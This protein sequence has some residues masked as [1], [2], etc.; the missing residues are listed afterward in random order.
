M[1]PLARMYVWW[2]GM[3][4]EIKKTVRSVPSVRLFKQ[5]L[6]SLLSTLGN[7][8]LHHGWG[9]TWT[10][11]IGSTSSAAAILEL[12]TLFSHYG[13]PEIV[14]LGNGTGSTSR[15]FDDFLATNGI[16]HP[17]S[18]QNG[19]TW[20]EE[21]YCRFSGR[22]THSCAF[23]LLHYSSSTTGMA[24]D[25]LL[26]GCKMRTCLDDCDQIVPSG[27]KASSCSRGGVMIPQW[28]PA[29]SLWVI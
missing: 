18:S 11:L 15:V 16:K 2:P 6:P 26:L 1:R 9:Y 5:L 4:S 8:R 29:S 3:D 23:C 21:S 12:R 24:P 13:I 27:L 7:G 17:M 19:K 28:D 22:G 20:T 25:E 14:V 10:S